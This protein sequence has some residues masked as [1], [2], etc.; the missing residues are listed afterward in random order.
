MQVGV[1]DR[2]D[3]TCQYEGC[4]EMD[5][6]P[7]RCSNCHKRFCS[8]HL[9]YG[10][11]Q[12]T[13]VTDVR[14]G[15]CPLCNRVVSLEY[16]RQDVNEAVSWHMDRG[17]RDVPQG[18]SKGDNGVLSTFFGG[19]AANAGGGRRLGGGVRPCSHTGCSETSE[20]RVKCDQ[21]GRVFCLQHRGPLQ[22]ECRAAAA[23]SSATASPAPA[24]SSAAG[25]GSPLGNA[26]ASV[27]RLLA[28]PSNTPDKAVGKATELPSDMVTCLICFLIPSAS[29]AS[30]GT[31]CDAF[32]PVPSFFMYM[33]KNTAL[34]RLLDT[35]VDRAAMSSPAV[36]AGAAWKLYAVTLP[37][38]TEAEAAYYPPLPLST[39]VGKS[40]VGRAERAVLFLTPL[41]SLPPC[42]I[43]AVRDVD[44]KGSL[45]ASKSSSSGDGCHLM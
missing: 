22:H 15:T 44:R 18:S 28:H 20:T 39:V 13:A 2:D 35:A 29:S 21:C 30:T 19:S 4:T 42:V 45:K 5:L 25:L 16:P 7:A 32:A 40:A 27:A 9:A 43:E 36:R 8:H 3:Q 34:G 31:G 26:A 23:R 33:P 41:T 17:C 12:C 10:A 14:V 11:H 38:H 37:I 6:L 1:Y 24:A